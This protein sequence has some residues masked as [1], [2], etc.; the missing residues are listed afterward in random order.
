MIAKIF[1]YACIAWTIYLVMGFAYGFLKGL[2]K[3]VRRHLKNN[4]YGR[5]D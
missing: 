3:S 5:L 1:T 4:R 2:I